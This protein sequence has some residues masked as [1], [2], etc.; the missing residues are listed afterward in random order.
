MGITLNKLVFDTT[1]PNDGANVG[2]YLRADD[3]TLIGHTGGAL[4][5]NIASSSGL[6]IFAEDSAHASGDLGQ[7]I[8]AVRQDTPGSLV[9][10]DGDYAPLQV[11]ANGALR[12]N[13]TVTIGDNKAEDAAHASGDTGSFILSVRQDTLASSTSAD[14]DY[15]AFKTDALGRLRN[16]NAKQSGAYAAVSVGN[17]ATDIVGTDLANRTSIIIQ[18][19]SNKKVYIGLDSSVTTSNGLELGIGDSIEVEA[20]AGLNWHGIVG[21]GTADV[22]Y[23]EF[24]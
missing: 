11:D 21:S 20:G 10:A 9:G 23:M 3:G 16:S 8:L 24:V 14:G 1:V 6:G 7:Q 22:R 13:A 2:A 5:V 19:L 4:D 15:Q 17:T 18:N 12:V